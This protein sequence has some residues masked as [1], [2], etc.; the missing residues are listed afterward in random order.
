MKWILLGSTTLAL[1]G[2]FVY[3]AVKWQGVKGETVDKE[4]HG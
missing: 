2:Y 4:W 1:I 3:R